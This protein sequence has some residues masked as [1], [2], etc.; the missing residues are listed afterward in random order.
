M[1][2]C[3][4]CKSEID[5][6]AKVCP[7]CRKSQSSK[8]AKIFFILLIAIIFI[9]VLKTEIFPNDSNLTVDNNTVTASL[10][11][12]GISFYIEGNLMNNS[13]KNFNYVEVTYT[14]YDEHQNTLGTCTDNNN[15]LEAN[16]TWK[17]K[18]ICPNY[19]NAS[20]YKL[21]KVNGW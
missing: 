10:D 13:D 20:S 16:G 14:I 1:K 2:K 4:C 9:S 17:F 21:T 8:W 15:G 11:D 7:I 5:K 19:E 3:R 6:K 12:Y 18:I